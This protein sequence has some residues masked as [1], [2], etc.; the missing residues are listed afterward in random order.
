MS[1]ND[2][3]EICFDLSINCTKLRVEWLS[4]EGI[5][6]QC[7]KGNCI[8]LA[9]DPLAD[10]E[11][12]I[13][14]FVHCD[15]CTT[16]P[17][18][19]KKC[20]C[21]FNTDCL[22]CE[23][24]N[25]IPGKK[26]G[27]CEGQLTEQQKAEGRLCNGDC[28]PE[29]PY[30]N[31]EIERC[32][33]CIEGSINPD[34]P[35]LTCLQG[36][37]T[38]KCENCD[39]SSGE[40]K[41]CLTNTDCANNTDG[42]NCCQPD[43]KCG[44]CPGFIWDPVQNKCIIAPDCNTISDCKE[45]EDCVRVQ[46]PN[47]SYTKKCQPIKCPDGQICLKG[48]CVTACKSQSC[49]NGADCGPDCGCIEINGIKQCVPCETLACLGLCELALGC[50][51]NPDTNKC[52]GLPACSDPNCTSGSP[53]TDPNCTCYKDECV[54][55]GNFPCNPDDCNGRV[56]CGCSESGECNGG[57]ACK[58]KLAINKLQNC[59]LPDGCQLEGVL[60][61][62]NG[63]N[64]NDIIVKTKNIIT[65]ITETDQNQNT[66]GG[67]LGKVDCNRLY[68]YPEFYKRDVPYKDYKIRAE[69]ADNELIEGN[70][71]IIVEHYVINFNG[72]M[73]L[74]SPPNVNTEI[75]RN[76]VDNKVS[77]IVVD[78]SMF[79][80]LYNYTH[81]GQVHSLNTIVKVLVYAEG[82]KVPVNNCIDYKRTKVA[83]YELNFNNSQDSICNLIQTVYA[84]EQVKNL[85]DRVSKRKPLFVWSKSS[86]EIFSKT[87][88]N[89]LNKLYIGK[90]GSIRKA[91]G[92]LTGNK[93][94]DRLSSPDSNNELHNNYN[95]Q[96]NVDCGCDTIETHNNLNFCCINAEVVFANCNTKLAIEPFKVCNVNGKLV[97]FETASYKIADEAQVN[98]KIVIK[99]LSGKEI[100]ND[101]VYLNTDTIREYNYDSINDPIISV[102]ILQHYVGGLLAENDCFKEYT[103]NEVI[104]PNVNVNIDCQQGSD[105][106][107]ITAQQTTGSDRRIQKI[108]LYSIS[109]DFTFTSPILPTNNLFQREYPK[110]I[111]SKSVSPLKAIITFVGGCIDYQDILPCTVN[112]TL[113]PQGKSVST[114]KCENG[115]GVNLLV[116]PEFF[117]ES[118]YITYQISG[119]DLPNTITVT[120]NEYQAIFE[121]LGAGDYTVVATQ[122][123]LTATTFIKI[124]EAVIPT[125]TL[126]S[127]ICPGESGSLTITAPAGSIFNVM[128][129][130][131]SL[132]V[133]PIPN[134]GSYTITGLTAA[135][136]Y[137]VTGGID[138]NNQTCSPF[139][140][141]GEMIFGG[142]ILTPVFSAVPY[143][144]CIGVPIEFNVWDE[145]GG[146]V[147]NINVLGGVVTNEMGNVITQ[148]ISGQTYFFTPN[149][150]GNDAVQIISVD[151]TCDTLSQSPITKTFGNLLPAPNITNILNTCANGI[152]TVSANVTISSG[153]IT[154]VTIGGITATN[155]GSTYSV[156]GL[157]QNTDV[158][159]I[160]TS[161][162]GCI[163][164]KSIIVAN[165]NCPQATLTI[166]G[167]SLPLCGAQVITLTANSQLNPNIATG[168]WTYQW[169]EQAPLNCNNCS[170]TPIGTP[171][172]WGTQPVSLQINAVDYGAYYLVLTNNLNPDC[173]Y[174]SNVYTYNVELPPSIPNIQYT[175]NNVT[176][177]N[178]V[179]FSTGVSFYS[180]YEWYV[181]G[182]TIPVST[183]ST[184]VFTP[185]VSGPL[186]V[187]VVVS[188]GITSC[189][190]E[191]TI[192]LTVNNDCNLIGEPRITGTTLTCQ[193][194]RN[195]FLDFNNVGSY[196]WLI[197]AVNGA[198]TSSLVGQTGTGSGTQ[199]TISLTTPNMEP[200]EDIDN[201]SFRFTYLN[202]NENCFQDFTVAW[203]YTRCASPPYTLTLD[204]TGLWRSSGDT[205]STLLSL[206]S[207]QDYVFLT[208]ISIVTSVNGSETAYRVYSN[209]GSSTGI[210][211]YILYHDTATTT[212]LTDLALVQA[213]FG[214]SRVITADITTLRNNVQADIDAIPILQGITVS[215]SGGNLVFGN[216]PC[217][218]RMIRGTIYIGKLTD[219][220]TFLSKP[221]LSQTL[222]PTCWNN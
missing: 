204:D 114:K 79:T 121:N 174:T 119:G 112:L 126:T 186:A 17:I 206:K 90:S 32:V 56:N 195:I 85:E 177:G 91:Y 77:T 75:I 190:S 28:P 57:K 153:T 18:Y 43:G 171:G 122:D 167:P 180:T 146:K 29:K 176:V 141:S 133:P 71:R 16:D 118:K 216:L 109:Q 214:S 165:C 154:S 218:I 162:N 115:S 54:H 128:S 202:G 125:V 131:G 1:N 157:V 207:S 46:L 163:S 23:Q 9:P 44:C 110:V 217:E 21:E 39:P 41:Q 49:E 10:G 150:S 187:R 3:I 179:T 92:T 65:N 88:F 117:D 93:Y 159:I 138:N 182:G 173:T 111:N 148:I 96:L 27:I 48:K 89:S 50:K 198:T 124:P 20:F 211:E 178:S 40:C 30:F 116:I 76:I 78:S 136:T 38:L 24:C 105:N 68:I 106:F 107:K 72:D 155:V 22:E 36:E 222:E 26:F 6:I 81:N 193:A 199:F 129:P 80:K 84:Q 66:D 98:Y 213:Y 67:G 127:S 13:E 63:C 58:D 123:N 104:L 140:W 143:Q 185:V 200:G 189:T 210:H 144:N 31:A 215:V 160:A 209:P 212:C 188:N 37:W 203:D 161:S 12:C 70:I 172:S 11:K 83:E 201:I 7:D 132:S 156:S 87:K 113:E 108:E 220:A 61:L 101:L 86:G 221:Q 192:N 5:L 74:V 103:P 100:T 164:T 51:C 183:N 149:N 52:E 2:Y 42:R 181:N 170:D 169:Y 64:C 47:G 130:I 158:D 94:I 19:F 99:L 152:T 137:T 45:C 166:T 35:C 14:G 102:K 175:P 134:N 69:F 60:D 4:R 191:N 62:Q 205:T 55:C 197:T 25:K 208:D 219:C 139:N 53:C 147:Y 194:S 34:N 145:I 142:Q 120:N 15:D 59:T 73:E 196:T 33:E 184:F 168:A 95:Y 82:I 8:R 135:G 97:N 151:S